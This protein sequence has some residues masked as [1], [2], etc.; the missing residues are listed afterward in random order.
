MFIKDGAMQY[1]TRLFEFNSNRKV[2]RVQ[3]YDGNG[4][5]DYVCSV[6]F[7]DKEGNEMCYF[8]PISKYHPQAPGHEIRENE[9]LIGVYGVKNKAK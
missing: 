7:I 9:E 6:S 8:R 2:R 5:G 1:R 3:A 4:R